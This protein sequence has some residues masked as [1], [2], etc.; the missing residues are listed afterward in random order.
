M[1]PLTQN[2]EYIIKKDAAGYSIYDKPYWFDGKK[3]QGIYMTAPSKQD[4]INAVIKA[5]ATYVEE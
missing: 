5:D 3:C 1:L 2:R 4:C